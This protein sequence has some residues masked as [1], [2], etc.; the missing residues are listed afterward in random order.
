MEDGSTPVDPVSINLIEYD[1]MLAPGDSETDGKGN[2]HIG[3]LL[4]ER[5][6]IEVNSRA[7]SYVKSI[8][9]GGHDITPDNLD[10][11]SGI[12]GAM[13]IV[14]SPSAASVAG[15]VRDKDGNPAPFAMVELW[16]ASRS[17][18]PQTPTADSN[19]S[20]NFSNLTPGDYWIAAWDTVD[21]DPSLL[22]NPDFLARFEGSA[23]KVS[24]RESANASIEVTM[25]DHETTAAEVAMLH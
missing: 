16:S 9:F 10:L 24:L 17:A 20:F 19:G 6:R 14:L 8:R 21:I 5:Y 15:V 22:Q 18:L 1:P 23:T 2:F 3:K 4:P 25:N 12:G 11:R 13:D 7:K